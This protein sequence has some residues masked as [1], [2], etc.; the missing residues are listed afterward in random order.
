MTLY[1][2]IIAATNFSDTANNAV[3]Y[4]AGFAKATGTKLILFHSFSLSIHSA[5]SRISSEGMQQ[6]LDQTSLR[7][8]RLGTEIATLFEIEVECFCNYSFLEDQ[9]H[10]LI[11]DTNAQ[12]VVMGMAD[13][14]LE[15]DLMGN[16][17][18]A[19]IKN[20]NIPVLAVPANARFL[21]LKKI[22]FAFDNESLSSIEKLSW[23]ASIAELLKAEVEFFSV[24]E[25][26]EELLLEQEKINSQEEQSYMEVKF[27]YK[28][29]RSGAVINEIKKEI[30]NYN[31]DILVMVPQKYGFWDSIVHISK[32]RIMASGLDIPL[33]SLP[34]F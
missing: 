26:V 32:T 24:N 29:I 16:A 1:H 30:K 5:N 18:T 31:A 21:N 9:L 23:F 27:V 12:L 28:N 17:T 6:E 15:Q 25:K 8:E 2:A 10:N 33:L 11:E 3:T 22:L 7:L 13:R 34:N 20:T 4:A 14:S 19:I